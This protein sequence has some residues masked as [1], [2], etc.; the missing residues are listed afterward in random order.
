MLVIVEG[1]KYS[2]KST[3]CLEFQRRHGGEI[4]HFPTNSDKG[5]QAM[6]L[7]ETDYDRAQDM[8]LEDINETISQLDPNKLYI[9]DRSFISNAVYRNTEHVVIPEKYLS[10]ID[11]SMVVF[12]SVE[13][14]EI[15]RRIELRQHKKMTVTEQSKLLWS[16]NRFKLVAECFCAEELRDNV[17]VKNIFTCTGL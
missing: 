10:V 6:R 4:I 11:D 8:M 17:V 14:D 1:P 7:L 15:V 16:Y 13:W 2:G 9:L 5:Q 3:F 12:M